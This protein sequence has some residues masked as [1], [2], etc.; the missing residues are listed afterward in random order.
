MKRKTLAHG[1]LRI[2]AQR[3]AVVPSLWFC[4]KNTGLLSPQHH[5]FSAS[6]LLSLQKGLA[7]CLPK[8]YGGKASSSNLKK[9]KKKRP[10]KGYFNVEQWN[11][12]PNSHS[13]VHRCCCLDMGRVLTY[14]TALLR[15]I[16]SPHLWPAVLVSMPFLAFAGCDV[17]PLQEGRKKKSLLGVCTA[18]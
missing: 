7:S 16:S 1:N 18:D 4:D 8:F 3:G 17:C 11:N 14:C 10:A 15:A 12:H 5:D 9:K 13:S 2:K 6:L